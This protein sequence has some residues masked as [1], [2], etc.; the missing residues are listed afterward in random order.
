MTIAVHRVLSVA[1]FNP[2]FH[3]E[4]LRRYRKARQGIAKNAKEFSQSQL[5][6]AIIAIRRV[7]RV[8]YSTIL[9][10]QKLRKYRKGRQ[11]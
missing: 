1:V 2:T 3:S 11:G 8:L 5:L 7:L 9:S 6:F 4:V 10:I